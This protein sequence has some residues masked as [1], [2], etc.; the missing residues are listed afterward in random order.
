[1]TAFWRTTFVLALGAALL[2]GAV[3]ATVAPAAAQQRPTESEELRAR[4]RALLE[5]CPDLGRRLL[6]RE[7]DAW[8]ELDLDK[9]RRLERWIDLLLPLDG[10]TLAKLLAPAAAAAADSQM[11][12]AV[13]ALDAALIAAAPPPPTDFRVVILCIG[14]GTSTVSRT[15]A[16]ALATESHTHPLMPSTVATV[17]PW[18]MLF[19]KFS[20]K[21]PRSDLFLAMLLQGRS[22]PALDPQGGSKQLAAPSVGEMYRQF[23][24]KAKTGRDV[25]VIYRGVDLV[26]DFSTAKGWGDKYAQIAL[27]ADRMHNLSK[28]VLSDEVLDYRKTEKS[29]FDAAQTISELSAGKLRVDTLYADAKVSGFIRG[30]VAR[31]TGPGINSDVFV[32][33]ATADLLRSDM[34]ARIVIARLGAAPEGPDGRLANT[35]RDRFVRDTDRHVGMIWSASRASDRW[36]GRTYFWVI[37]ENQSVAWVAGPGITPGTHSAASPKLTQVAPTVLRM[38]GVDVEA[39]MAGVKGVSKKPIDELFAPPDADKGK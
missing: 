23:V 31:A 9:R 15:I 17:R 26:A 4:A 38:L 14:G 12:E 20:A 19:T 34:D 10:T 33:R 22:Q 27:Y 3:P 32:A 7:L 36:R 30:Q 6:E 39:A 25:W 2:A 5:R 8:R 28:D 11:S 21:I 1:M 37:V 35:D 18:G 16:Q 24:G 13:K 29:P